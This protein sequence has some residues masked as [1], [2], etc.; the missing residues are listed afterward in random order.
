MLVIAGQKLDRIG[1]KIF[2]E[3]MGTSTLRGK[4]G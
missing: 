3:P 2:N 4:I 1:Y